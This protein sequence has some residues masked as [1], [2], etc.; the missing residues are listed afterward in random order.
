MF[1]ENII[2]TI[3]IIF[4]IMNVLLQYYLSLRQSKAISKSFN[5]VPEK[6]SNNVNLADHQKSCKYSLLKQAVNRYE[7]IYSTILLLLFI[8]G[9]LLNHLDNFTR[10]LTANIYLRGIY[11]IFIF[12]FINMV[13]SLPFSLYRTFKIE[14]LFGFNNTTIKVFFLDKIKGIILFLIIGTPLIYI[15]LKLM[16]IGKYWWLYVWGTWVLFSLLLMWI[17]PKWIAPIFNKFEELKDVFLKKK[18]ENLL[19]KSGFKSNG[20]FVMDGSKRSGHSNAYFT[21]IGKNKRIV[22]FDTLLKGILPQELEAIL[23]HELGHF[24]YKHIL[25]QII[26][27]FIL[28]LITLF[29]LSNLIDNSYVYNGFGVQNKS[30]AMALILLILVTP[31]FTF[32]FSPLINVISRKNEYE[33]DRFAAKITNSKDLISALIKLYSKNAVNLV[34]DKYYSFFYDSHPHAKDRINVLEK[35]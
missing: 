21:G 34:T 26:F 19:N 12:I 15:I 4:I 22:F 14:S 2:S 27:N 25:K 35:Y 24:K 32:I 9:G 13:L 16:E 31:I 7:I 11:L 17:F 28:I 20:I 10:N 6:F 1:K 3:F 18:I 33:A 23:A 30:N 8:Y 29:I 5:F